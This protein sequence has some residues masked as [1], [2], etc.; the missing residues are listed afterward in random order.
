MGRVPYNQVRR[1][2][3]GTAIAW[4][5]PEVEDDDAQPW[6]VIE[7]DPALLGVEHDWHPDEY[8]AGWTVLEP[9]RD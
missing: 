5:R 4:H 6:L 1:R 2:P 7:E 8:V 3:D 9:A